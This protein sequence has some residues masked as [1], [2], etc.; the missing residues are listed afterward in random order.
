MAEKSCR[1]LLV[2]ILLFAFCIVPA[3]AQTFDY[4]SPWVT[5][6]TTNSATI[7]WRSD[8]NDS[9]EI[10]YDTTSYFKQHNSFE[11]MTPVPTAAQYQHVQLNGLEP[12]TSYTYWVKPS[13]NASAF[14]NRTFQTMPVSGPFTFIVVGDTREGRYYMETKRFKYVADAIANESN[15]LFILHLGDFARF[16]NDTRWA[17]FFP[18]C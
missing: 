5:Q 14:S 8:P 12:N 17:I 11:Y 18:M 1:N 7:N 16:D 9:G 13:G 6:T 3:I 4:W 2:L 10:Y 15:V